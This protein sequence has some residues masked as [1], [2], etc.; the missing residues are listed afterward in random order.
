MQSFPT[1]KKE[2]LPEYYHS[3]Y[4][5]PKRR[6]KSWSRSSFSC[7]LRG[8]YSPML[9]ISR[10][11]K[12][13]NHHKLQIGTVTL[14]DRR[15]CA[16]LFLLFQLKCLPRAVWSANSSCFDLT[17]SIDFQIHAKTNRNCSTRFRAKE[18]KD[19]LRSSSL[20]RVN[21][22]KRHAWLNDGESFSCISFSIVRR[23]DPCSKYN[24]V[25]TLFIGLCR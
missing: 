17:I 13:P 9:H 20:C 19:E 8:M 10:I 24:M 1:L 11:L 25:Y 5:K 18:T 15:G 6:G 16:R 4:G 7:G 21:R 12:V 2:P 3:V 23:I 22:V 14:A